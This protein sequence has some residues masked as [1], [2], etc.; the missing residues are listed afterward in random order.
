M[1]LLFSLNLILIS[2]DF[3]VTSIAGIFFP[4]IGI[5][6][7]KK[8]LGVSI[9]ESEEYFTILKP[10]SSLGLF[11]GFVVLLPLFD[12]Y[13]YREIIFA[14]LFL[15]LFRAYL[16]FMYFR[17]ANAYFKLQ[18]GRNLF[19]IGLIFLS[20]AILIIQLIFMR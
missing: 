16:R 8:M 14:T 5:R 18:W 7:Y 20:S 6:L 9:P 1:E 4:R 17:G 2:L 19:H 10:W 12:P 3:I 11:V 13:R 15:L